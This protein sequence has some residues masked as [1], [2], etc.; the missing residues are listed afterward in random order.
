MFWKKK[1]VG[2][3]V[4]Y[5]NKSSIADR[6]NSGV[7]FLQAGNIDKAIDV[8][9][10]MVDSDHPSAIY[11]LALLYT[12]GHG[13]RLMLPE[14]PQLMGKAAKL[15]HAGAAKHF[16]IYQQFQGFDPENGAGLSTLLKMTG[17]GSVPLILIN[18]IGMDLLIRMR[19]RGTCYMYVFKEIT[20]ILSNEDTKLKSIAGKFLVKLSPRKEVGAELS[21]SSE[22]THEADRLSRDCHKNMV[23]VINECMQDRGMDKATAMFI[24]C[25]IIGMICKSNDFTNLTDLP[26]IEFYT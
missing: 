16:S 14:A 11:N 20:D 5:G 8:F 6:Y 15:G 10:S 1:S 22:D 13:K 24:R 21:A 23:R 19:G 9:S 17:D 12:Q 18:A 26:P 3:V 4:S 2:G 7:G 25:S